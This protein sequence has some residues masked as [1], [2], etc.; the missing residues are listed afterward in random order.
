MY[1]PRL[2]ETPNSRN[3][4]DTFLGYN[5]NFKTRNGEFY[6]MENLSSDNFPLLSPRKIRPVLKEGENV[7][8]LLYSDNNIAW[9]E[10]DILHYSLQDWDLT[11][12]FEE[13]GI[14]TG[15]DEW[16]QM[17]RFGSY[18]I[19]YPIGFYINVFA[20]DTD[21]GTLSKTYSV[22]NGLT[23]H[24]RVSTS[25]GGELQ[26]LTV[27]KEA[28]ENPA[29]GDYWLC[30]QEASQGLNMWN[31]TQAMWEPVATSYIKIEIEDY[32]DDL[33]NYFDVGD[34]LQ[35]NTML[36]DVNDGSTII[37]M[38]ANWFTVI[39]FPEYNGTLIV[40]YEQLTTDVYTLEMRRGLPKLDYICSSGNRLWGCRYGLS[41]PH[42]VVNEIYC[43][44][45]GD[46]KNWFTYTGIASDSYAVSVGV[47]GAWTGCIDFN[48]YPLF[49]KEDAIFKIYGSY[50]AEFRVV[51]SHVR[52]VQ[53][54]SHKSLA[55][56]GETL[57][58]KSPTDIVAYD[59][60][61]PVSI[62]QALGKENHYY[63]AIGGGCQN[64]YHI[65]MQ[66]YAGHKFYFIYDTETGI[67]MKQDAPN[68]KEFSASENG[69]MYAA[70]T[71]N[72]IGLGNTD[73]IV[74][75][76]TLLGEEWVDWWAQT[77]EMGYE[78]PDFKYV[79]KIT[80][81]AYVPFRSEIQVQISY[82]DRMFEDVG[83]IRGNDD[84]ATQ[85]ININPMRC[86]HYRIKFIGHGDCRI[87]SMTYT[88]E[89]GS[90]DTYGST[91]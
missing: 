81:R 47:P 10:G 20:H 51:Q 12:V 73:N 46:F 36:S 69:Q 87:Y 32:E 60:A 7:R 33:T 77:G 43:S 86:D 85:N 88:L 22:P 1:Y 6:D 84:I 55:I 3:M 5:H 53:N 59:G 50:P 52:G 45:L 56:V 4:I 68:I 26:N 38:G 82:D 18:I 30:T 65:V 34:T 91:Y 37:N 58:Y 74:F 89:T 62:S 64:K 71:E 72:V 80:I 83:I 28:P 70:T 61:S 40:D 25:E 29:N 76:E 42:T 19:L 78:Y 79:S 17:I 21:Y 41:N 49:F 44:K 8:G 27:G 63:S 2:D 35:L 31:E 67:W 90:E 39:G 16:Q 48:G 14:E 24:Y 11:E 9:L 54:G 66:N 23:V 57:F 13:L 15:G 75:S